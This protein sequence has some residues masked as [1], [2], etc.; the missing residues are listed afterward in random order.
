MK[1]TDAFGFGKDVGERVLKTAPHI[2]QGLQHVDRFD[3][4]RAIRPS[5]GVRRPLPRPLDQRNDRV[6]PVR[7]TARVLNGFETTGEFVRIMIRP[8]PPVEEGDDLFVDGCG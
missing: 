7:E 8:K 3:E 5:I 4:P 2:R 6:E 1:A